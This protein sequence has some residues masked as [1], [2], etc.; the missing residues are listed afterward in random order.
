MVHIMTNKKDLVVQD[1]ALINASYSLDLVEKRLILLAIAKSRKTGE[2][3]NSKDYI[4]IHS[5]EYAESFNVEK[6]ASYKAL[7]DASKNLFHRYFSFE[8]LS[9]KGNITKHKSRWVS[10][11]AYIENESIVKLIFSTR[12]IPLVQQ[13]EKSFTSYF[14]EDIANLTSIYAIRLYE[15]IIAWRST[16]QTPIFK[17]DEFKDKLG[18]EVHEYSAMKD[19]KKNVLDIAIRQ[20][21]QHTNIQIEL[22]QHKAGRKISGFSFK[23]IE[24]KYEPEQLRDTKTVDWVDSEPVIKPKRKSITKKQAE[25]LAKVG[26]T[27]SELIIRLSPDY[28]IK[29]L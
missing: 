19:F 25:K 7:K 29:D 6:H 4:E 24:L 18:V 3:I 12:V 2:A 27:W 21:N 11:I 5:S 17:Y 28:F 10:E 8:S 22:E 26:E 23:F 14:I 13:L 1:N 9:S 20:I 15:L 16:K